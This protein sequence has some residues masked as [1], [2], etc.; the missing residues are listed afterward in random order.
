MDLKWRKKIICTLYPH[1]DT[2]PKKIHIDVYS[3]KGQFTWTFVKVS[4]VT[5]ILISQNM[6][7]KTTP[8]MTESTVFPTSVPQ[9]YLSY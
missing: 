9:A 2:E 3:T 5:E 6:Q 4:W 1:E 7:R 8:R